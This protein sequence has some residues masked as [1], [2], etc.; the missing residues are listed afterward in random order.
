MLLHF[1]QKSL[2][3]FGSG[4]IL[5]CWLK[6]DSRVIGSVLLVAEL[7][8]CLGIRALFLYIFALGLEVGC[9]TTGQGY[10]TVFLL[11]ITSGN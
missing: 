8:F 3:K 10:L 11:D 5:C 7:K 2:V 4:R 9:N 6:R 1:G